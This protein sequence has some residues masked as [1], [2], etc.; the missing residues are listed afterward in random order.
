MEITVPQLGLPLKQEIQKDLVEQIA[1]QLDTEF[2]LKGNY[3]LQDKL[4]QRFQLVPLELE[5]LSG[6]INSILTKRDLPPYQFKS[7][8]LKEAERLHADLDPY[9]VVACSLLCDTLDKRAR[10]VKLK[11]IG[12]S[13]KRFNVL[14]E[15]KEHLEFY[16]KRVDKAFKGTSESA[17]LSLSKNVEAGDLQSIKYFHEF[18]QEYDPNQELKLNLNKLINLF[19]E[20]L[21]HH[22]PVET[23]EAISRDFEIKLLEG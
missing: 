1:T 8:E 20:V 15:D 17:K 10:S 21:V 7:S 14:L 11:A 18:S 3:P 19:M 2:W 13:S 5:E 16:R 22:V 6:R 9:F 4:E 12:M 23:V